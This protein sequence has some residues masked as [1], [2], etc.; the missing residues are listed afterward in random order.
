MSNLLISTDQIHPLPNKH[1]PQ[2][3]ALPPS[4]GPSQRVARKKVKTSRKKKR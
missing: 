4:G 3:V 1:V 2:R